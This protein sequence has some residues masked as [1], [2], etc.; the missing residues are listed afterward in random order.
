MDDSFFV[1]RLKRF[2]NLLGD[3]Q[4]VIDNDWAARDE[5]RQGKLLRR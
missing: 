4:R 3:R 2:R 1:R 5:F